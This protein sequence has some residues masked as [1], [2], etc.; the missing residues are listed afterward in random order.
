MHRRKHV[1]NKTQG[2]LAHVTRYKHPL[3][4][5]IKFLLDQRKD[6]RNHIFGENL[7]HNS[8]SHAHFNKVGALKILKN[9]GYINFSSSG[10]K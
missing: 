7:T 2:D 9:T 5:V 10:H 8:E 4:W 3:L 1:N 6:G